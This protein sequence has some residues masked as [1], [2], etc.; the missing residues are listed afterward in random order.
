[1]TLRDI[2]LYL[3]KRALAEGTS[4]PAEAAEAR[5]Q[6]EAMEIEFPGIQTRAAAVKRALEGDP[7]RGDRSAGRGSGLA[8]AAGDW[9]RKAAQD[10]ASQAAHDLA[11]A[12]AG[13]ARYEALRRG[14]CKLKAHDCAAD[15]VCL[16]VR[17]RAADILRSRSR[18][19]ILDAVEAE[20]V[21][22]AKN[23]DGA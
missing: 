15:Q 13:S 12:M 10:V 18:A 7:P 6:A 3:K 21:E 23:A 14:Q 5:R 1:M 19:A 2:D 9:L 17:V 4:A 8:E 16:E 11:G 22:L 20:L